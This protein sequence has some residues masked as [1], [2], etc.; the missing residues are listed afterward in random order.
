MILLDTNYILRYLLRDDEEMFRTSKKVIGN[1]H[2]FVLES[3]LAEVVYVLSGVYK[4]PKPLISKTLSQFISLDNIS[5]NETSS[6]F[7]TALEFYQSKN[8]DFVDC[9][10]CARKNKFEIKSFDKK[11][12]KCIHDEEA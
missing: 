11:L 6:T 2:C 4:I 3:V 12:T 8:L 5:M 1:Q 9:C 10:L 7:I